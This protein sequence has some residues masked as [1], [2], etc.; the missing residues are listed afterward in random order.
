MTE[1][2]D[3][4][5]ELAFWVDADSF[6]F[7]RAEKRAPINSIVIMK[8]EANSRGGASHVI[9]SCGIVSKEGLVRISR[10]NASEVL[11]NRAV[12]YVK[13]TGQWPPYMNIKRVLESGDVELTF[14]ITEL[15]SF[16]LKLTSE[17]VDG[18]PF[19]FLMS[20]D[21]CERSGA[22]RRFTYQPT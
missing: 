17:M 15:D 7:R 3:I 1:W 12:D 2:I 16:I 18:D 20:L 4:E 21:Q 19:E 5:Y 14:T 10:R 22:S 9:T 6:D 11:S 13:K 8:T